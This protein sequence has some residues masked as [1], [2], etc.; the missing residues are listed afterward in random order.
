[1]TRNEKYIFGDLFRGN[2]SGLLK[3]WQDGK[4]RDSPTAPSSSFRCRYGIFLWRRSRRVLFHEINKLRDEISVSFQ[5]RSISF[6]W[7]PTL[8]SLLPGRKKTNRSQGGF[9]RFFYLLSFV[10]ASYGRSSSGSRSFGGVAKRDWSRWRGPISVGATFVRPSGYL[11]AG[12]C[13]TTTSGLSCALDCHSGSPAHGILTRI[14]MGT[15]LK[16]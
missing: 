7:F 2:G 10:F 6:F 12:A 13:T 11:N 8:K 1:M 9:L 14:P 16:R 15:F 3:I 4:G 5:S